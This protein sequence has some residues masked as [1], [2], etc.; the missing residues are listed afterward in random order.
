[1]HMRQEKNE[2]GEKKKIVGHNGRLARIGRACLENCGS[3]FKLLQRG[4][5]SFTVRCILY[6]T[7][8]YIFLILKYNS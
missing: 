5:K 6:I 3:D 7:Y 4:L 2:S 1:M 8:I